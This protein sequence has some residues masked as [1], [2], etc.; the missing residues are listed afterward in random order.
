[1]PP[2]SGGNRFDRG[3]VGRHV[4]GQDRNL[5]AIQDLSGMEVLV[6]ECGE[7]R[8]CVVGA[9]WIICGR[10]GRS[11]RFFAVLC[12]SWRASSCPAG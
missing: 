4:G 11:G 10:M 3:A 9:E 6:D 5:P 8:P 1:M 2:S 12:G 7:G